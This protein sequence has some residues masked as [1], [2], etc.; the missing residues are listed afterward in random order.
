LDVTDIGRNV[1]RIEGV[2]RQAPSEPA[3]HE[4]P[5][6]LA[7]YAERIAA[8]FETPERFGELFST[9]LVISPTKLLI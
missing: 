1:V 2:A 3:A 8:L 5:A 6:Y 7:K 9:P 4:N